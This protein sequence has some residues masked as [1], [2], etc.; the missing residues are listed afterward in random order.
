MWSLV[1]SPHVSSLTLF[2]YFPP[3][4]LCPINSGAL[5]S[6]SKTLAVLLVQDFC[7]SSF[8]CLEGLSSGCLWCLLP[9]FTQIFTQMALLRSLPDH[10]NVDYTHLLSMPF[11]FFL[12][13]FSLFDLFYLFVSIRAG[14]FIHFIH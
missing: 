2:H 6:S 9:H 14:I 10:M 8:L 1:I 13:N 5:R 11:F 3:Y 4:L 7:I 12:Q